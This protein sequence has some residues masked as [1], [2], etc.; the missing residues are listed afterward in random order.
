MQYDVINWD[1]YWA[2]LVDLYHAE[3]RPYSTVESR[4]NRHYVDTATSSFYVERLFARLKDAGTPYEFAAHTAPQ[5]WPPRL[6][7]RILVRQ[8]DHA[9]LSFDAL[10]T[11]RSDARRFLKEIEAA[12][13]R[14]GQLAEQLAIDEE[15]RQLAKDAEA[16]GLTFF[17]PRRFWPGAAR[18]GSAGSD[19]LN[20]SEEPSAS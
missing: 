5:A 15:M 18:R 14:I 2:E 19:G 17:L 12:S 9:A 13:P 1:N 6:W 8:A 16:W 7:W 4:Y 20:D 10:S 3:G 11:L